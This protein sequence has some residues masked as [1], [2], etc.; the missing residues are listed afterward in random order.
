MV[1]CALV[2]LYPHICQIISSLLLIAGDQDINEDIYST[3]G[4]YE[5]LFLAL[6]Q[7]GCRLLSSS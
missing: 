1:E 6:R 5:I 2:I 7:F 4:V 3:S